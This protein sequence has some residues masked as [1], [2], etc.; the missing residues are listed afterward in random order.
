MNSKDKFTNKV[1]DYIKYR[2]SY[3]KELIDY[4]EIEAGLADDSI[5]ADVGA[6]TGIFTMLLA[7]KVGKVYA[8]EPNFNMR[9]ACI[10]YCSDLNNFAAVDGSAEDTNLSDKSVDYVTVAQAFHW[11]DRQK[12]KVEFQR[13]LKPHGKAILIWNS[14][15]PESELIK[16]NDEL[17]RSLCP[18]FSGFSGGSG[19]S[20]LLY[21]DF[22]KDGY[23]EY[24]EFDNNRLLTLESYIGSSLSASYAPSERDENY[25]SF[26]DGLTSLFHKYSNNSVLILPN[27]TRCYV[28]K[29]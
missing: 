12:T 14:R 5:V 11:F 6:G 20:P 26:I 16:E 2:P 8:V 28:G 4:I 21:S 19:F 10:Q 23:C 7:N 24:R 17:C 29:V 18:E 1:T 13:I 27:R 25:K 3:P 22:F 15:V 9:T